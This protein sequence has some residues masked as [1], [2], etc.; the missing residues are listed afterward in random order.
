MVWGARIFN[1]SESKLPQSGQDRR[2]WWGWKGVEDILDI[3]RGKGN[4]Q[5]NKKKAAPFCFSI[6][7]SA[8]L[9]PP[10][11]YYSSYV[12]WT[13]QE[14][15]TNHTTMW[16]LPLF[17]VHARNPR[18]EFAPFQEKKLLM[19]LR[20]FPLG[21]SGQSRH[22]FHTLTIPHPKSLKNFIIKIPRIPFISSLKFTAQYR[23]VMGSWNMSAVCIVSC[24]DIWND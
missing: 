1:T 16:P 3:V 5:E 6:Y 18:C 9:P 13:W 10:V 2:Q 8:R 20:M 17:F 12:R 22:Q 14:K 24:I 11:H 23:K 21:R 7:L 19:P 15:V 4:G